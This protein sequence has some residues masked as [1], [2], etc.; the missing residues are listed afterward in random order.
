MN[1]KGF[2]FGGALSL[3]LLL[4]AFQ[5]CG[6][7]TLLGSLVAQSETTSSQ[8]EETP[9]PTPTTIQEPGKPTEY[10]QET[11]AT[12][13]CGGSYKFEERLE[14]RETDGAFRRVV[15][16]LRDRVTNQYIRPDR[17]ESTTQGSPITSPPEYSIPNYAVQG[18]NLVSIQAHFKNR[19]GEPVSL[20]YIFTMPGCPEPDPRLEVSCN[21]ISRPESHDRLMTAAKRHN[22]TGP[23]AFGEVD[24]LVKGI[25]E[26]PTPLQ[27][28]T[29]F[30]N[31]S[32][33]WIKIPN[34]KYLSM[35]FTAPPSGR[36]FETFVSGS[37]G[38]SVTMAISKCEGDFY[39]GRNAKNC[40]SPSHGEVSFL[41]G[42]GIPSD[43]RAAGYTCVLEPGQKYYLNI[44]GYNF[45]TNTPVN[46][47]GCTWFGGVRNIDL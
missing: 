31:S 15:F 46:E 20:G 2:L 25:I 47:S 27:T 37:G 32:T 45:S 22:N 17:W 18:C 21:E 26:R 10:N 14:Y 8:P 40:L 19:C 34:G 11:E 43:H 12:D 35:S 44:I 30:A 7:V 24:T 36:F 41:S 3:L 28:A 1:K 5:N 13:S 6:E 16:Q 4:V 33:N 23:Y 38:C 42:S 39:V 9:E 29:D